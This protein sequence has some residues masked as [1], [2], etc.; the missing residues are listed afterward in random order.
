M[1]TWRSLMI[2]KAC[3]ILAKIENILFVEAAG[4]T[5]VSRGGRLYVR[6]HGELDE[7]D[8]A[9]RVII[10]SGFGFVITSEAIGACAR[11]H[12]ELVITDAMQSF[13]AVY[14]GLAG[15]DARRSALKARA[16]QFAALADPRKRLEIAEAV[17]CRKIVAEAHEPVLKRA[18]IAE[19]AACKTVA[20]VRYVEA[21]SGRE[22]WR[23]WKDFELQFVKGCRPPAQWR[24]FS[25]RYI[26]RRQGRLGELPP[27]FNARFAETPLQAM[28]NFAASIIAARLVRVIVAKGLDPCFG[29][30]HDGR[31]PGRFSLAWDAIEPL[32]PALA[33]AVFDY[34]GA[35]MF[36][37][38]DFA[39]QDGVVRLSRE[40]VKECQTVVLEATPVGALVKAVKV[41]ADEL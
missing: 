41:I 27:Q 29:F 6:H 18:F 12:I 23:R 20:D 10:A 35:K 39:Q 7:I 9:V 17:I 11:R 21:R 31:K 34:A 28:H 37:L 13:T 24:S 30:L 15:G 33:E 40:V 5:I 38:L 2:G 1:Q 26:G 8:P 36:G 4:A 16:G 19:L 22:W 25:T 32:R 3:G 14:A